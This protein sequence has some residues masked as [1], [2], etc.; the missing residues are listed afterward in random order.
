MN[1]AGFV[2]HAAPQRALPDA[3]CVM[4]T[5]TIAGQDVLDALPRQVERLDPTD[6]E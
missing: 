3:H 1:P 2:V 4:H 5:H 6:K